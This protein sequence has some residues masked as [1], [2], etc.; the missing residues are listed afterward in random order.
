MSARSRRDDPVVA[1][2]RV[3]AS[4][5]ALAMFLEAVLR[6]DFFAAVY[7]HE[8]AI[9]AKE[10]RAMR[11]ARKRVPSATPKFAALVA[12]T[13]APGSSVLAVPGTPEETER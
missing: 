4:V 2:Y 10:W 5:D 12:R 6:G 13:G 7:H 9:G 1:R 3:A 11:A 8:M